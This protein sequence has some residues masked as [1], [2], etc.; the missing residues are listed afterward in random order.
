MRL[1][2]A[3]NTSCSNNSPQNYSSKDFLA[4]SNLRQSV[5]TDLGKLLNLSCDCGSSNSG[6]FYIKAIEAGE[7]GSN[8]CC[9][10]EPYYYAWYDLP[11]GC[12]DTQGYDCGT[13][14]FV[15]RACSGGGICQEAVI[16][17]CETGGFCDDEDGDGYYAESP[18]CPT[19][20]DCNDDPDA[21]GADI[22]P[23]KAEICDDD[24]NNGEGVDE[25]CNGLVNC[26]EPFCRN[27]PDAD[28]D[29]QCDKDNDGYF[30]EACGGNDCKDDPQQEPNAF[31]I[32]PG[33]AVE[34]TA[35]LCD[36]ELNNRHYRK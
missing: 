18:A 11:A 15:D 16:T 19:G 23:G 6:C 36:D 26:E 10:Q 17:P 8:A 28:C 33:S 24:G 30:S 20:N 3:K 2:S 35:Q 34:N 29:E 22:N 21:G 27:A 9:S 13:V 25:N 12:S 5:S 31:N 32:H 1:D 14:S 7:P 4:N